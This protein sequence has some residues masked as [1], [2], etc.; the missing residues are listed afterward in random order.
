M[1]SVKKQG[2]LLKKFAEPQNDVMPLYDLLVAK[3]IPCRIRLHPIIE[4][5]LCERL[6]DYAL[7]GGFQILIEKDGTVYSVIR[8][9]VSFGDYEIMNLGKGKKFKEPE[10]FKTPEELVEELMK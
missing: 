2:S 3:K 10:R 8:G 6:I 1:T 7:S 4:K 9:G 5:E